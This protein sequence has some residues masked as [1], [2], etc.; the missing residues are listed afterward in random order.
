MARS[1]NKTLTKRTKRR[2]NQ[3]KRTKRGGINDIEMGPSYEIKPIH[4]IPEDPIKMVTDNIRPIS[5]IQAVEEF[6]K[7]PPD[8]RERKER[9]NMFDE[10]SKENPLLVTMPSWGQNAGKKKKKKK[11]KTKQNKYHKKNT[12]NSK[13]VRK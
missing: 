1:K 9:Y 2:I 6:S 7:G 5:P 10:D 13:T 11:N 8:M 4:S 3:M 12:N